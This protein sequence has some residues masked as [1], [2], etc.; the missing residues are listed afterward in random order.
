MTD[1]K[2]LIIT[3][4]WPPSGGSGVQRWLKFVKYL[5]QFGWTPYVCTPENPSFDIRDESLIKDIPTE[6]EVLKL[7]IWEPY[8]AFKRLSKFFTGKAK[9]S[10]PSDFISRQDNSF[11]QKL[12]TWI[13]A[14]LFIPDPKVFWVRP[15]VK[16]LHDF[17][18]DNNITTVITT[19]PPHSIHLIGKKLKHKNPALHW[20]VDFRDPWS[21]WG[22][23]ESIRTSR[24]AMSI[25]K[26]ME[27]NVLTQ[28]DSIIAVTP[29]WQKML[30]HLSGKKVEL[31]TNGFDEDDFKSITHVRTANFVVRHVGV[32]NELCNPRPFMLALESLCSTH[33]EFRNKVKVEFIGEADPSFRKF[34]SE[35]KD[36]EEVTVFVK[37]ISHEELL[38]QYGTASVLLLVVTGYKS[39]ES[40]LPGKL[41]EYVASRLPVVGIGTTDGDAAFVLND[42]Q[43]G[44]MH[45]SNDSEA[46]VN[47]LKK[48]FQDWR[49]PA[50]ERGKA[51]IS[52]YSRKVITG[53]L[54]ELLQ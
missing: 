8:D 20:I 42:T 28:A 13:R 25:H 39:P 11:F 16:F 1:K 32:V 18:K 9:S 29:S 14:N 23:L 7:P 27:R 44:V 53:K 50:E 51:D 38:R 45:D 21:E 17:I 35:R 40:Y 33:Q 48:N 31:L 2:V 43:A 3:Y 24:W 10:K 22:F 41:F 46:I 6:A 12:S 47:T 37:S 4:Y 52:H 36:L 19:G 54:V 34:I 26:K 15:T 30:E 5:P 49:N